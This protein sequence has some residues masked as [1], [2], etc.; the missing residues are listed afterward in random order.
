MGSITM[1]HLHGTIRFPF[2]FQWFVLAGFLWVAPTFAGSPSPYVSSSGQAICATRLAGSP[3]WVHHRQMAIPLR[4]LQTI[5]SFAMIQPTTT[6]VFNPTSTTNVVTIPSSTAGDSSRISTALP[7]WYLTTQALRQTPST[8]FSGS[9]G[10]VLV[11][12]TVY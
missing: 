4:H 8:G 6:C 12:G 1:K 3:L 11:H 10:V 2:C 5:P 7:D 9:R